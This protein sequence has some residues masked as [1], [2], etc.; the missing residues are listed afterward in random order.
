MKGLEAGYPLVCLAAAEQRFLRLL[1]G[2]WSLA[3]TT[4][5][6]RL[7]DMN[8]LRQPWKSFN[9]PDHSNANYTCNFQARPR[10]Y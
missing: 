10:L 3:A 2:L 7:E 4:Q 1:P 9:L 6:A 8:S 5:A